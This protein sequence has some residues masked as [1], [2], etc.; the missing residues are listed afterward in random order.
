MKSC[1]EWEGLIA[2]SIY[3]PL[4]PAEQ[5][6]LDIHLEQCSQCNAEYD[7]LVLMKEL[8]PNDPVLFSGDLRRTLE[9]EVRSIGPVS[10]PMFQWLP[11]LRAL[12][13]VLF[14]AVGI[15]SYT[16][17]IHQTTESPTALLIDETTELIAQQRYIRAY[18]LLNEHLNNPTLS[19]DLEM[20]K[21]QGILAEL[22]YS[23]LRWYPRAYDSFN[24]LR[25]E[26]PKT[27]QASADYK[28]TLEILEE[29]RAI[30]SDYASLEDWDRLNTDITIPTLEAY[31]QKYPGTHQATEAVYNIARCLVQYAD[32]EHYQLNQTLEVAVQ[33][34]NNPLIVAQI[35]LEL[36][37]YYLEE[38]KDPDKARRI[39]REVE[40]GP[41]PQLSDAAHMTLASL[42]K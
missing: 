30:S 37:R 34:H 14:L 39:L 42:Q 17:F 6:S 7:S 13:L 24:T 20:A 18:T 38:G 31:I 19:K 16:T 25:T 32:L 12:S 4:E 10:K 28:R 29:S 1:T 36:G 15:F 21:V 26:Y 9:E 23:R 2:Q 11:S 41:V 5:R 27:F 40:A 3:E 33:S 8:I 35:K 22:T